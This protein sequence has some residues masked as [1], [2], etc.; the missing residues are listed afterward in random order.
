MSLPK[1]HSLCWSFRLHKSGAL[2]NAKG[3][4][5]LV[6]RLVARILS[7]PAWQMSLTFGRTLAVP[8][9]LTVYTAGRDDVVRINELD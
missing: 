7:V 4:Q 9:F 2:N 6:K 8:T 1:R 5:P 3:P